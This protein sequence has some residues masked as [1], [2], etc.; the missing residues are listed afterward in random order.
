VGP[1]RPANVAAR[2]RLWSLVG[3]HGVVELFEEGVVF[4]FAVGGG[5]A[6]GFDAFDEDLGGVGLRLDDFDDFVEVVLQRHGS[7]VGGLGTAHEFGL[8]VGGNKFDDLDVSGSEL[9]AQRL[10]VGVDGGFSGVV[11]G[12]EGH[13]G[14][15]EAGRDGH[16]R[17]VG[18]LQKVRQQGAGEAD[19]TEE[20]GVNGGFCVGSGGGLGEEV[21]GTHD[22]SVVD[23]DVEGGIVGNQF[24]CEGTDVGSVFDVEDCGGH[25]G[26]GGDSVVED[27]FAAAGDDD[28]V[29]EF[30]E[31]LREAAADTGAAAGDEDGVAGC[32]HGGSFS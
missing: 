14:E 7:R 15:R 10:A 27:L 2:T 3:V 32:F 24:C 18:L 22:A 12:G 4:F 28:F 19:G 20:V 1:V 26:I 16:D 11:G 6:E 23:D 30:M 9:V 29:A 8:D 25:A 13:R 31:G 5:E 17:G 21:F